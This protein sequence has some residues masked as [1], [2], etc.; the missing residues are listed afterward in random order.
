MADDVG[1]KYGPP[2]PPQVPGQTFPAVTCV[3]VLSA[4]FLFHFL[5]STVKVTAAD[6]RSGP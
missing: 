6:D 5:R 3:L 1:R 4:R 2:F